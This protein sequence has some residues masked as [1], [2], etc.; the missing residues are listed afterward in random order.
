[1]LE[2]KGV[3]SRFLR[4]N[5]TVVNGDGLEAALPVPPAALFIPEVQRHGLPALQLPKT[6]AA[7]AF[8]TIDVT[9]GFPGAMGEQ[10]VD[11]GM[12]GQ[13]ADAGFMSCAV[14]IVCSSPHAEK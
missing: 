11:R 5:E 7:E 2:I 12:L 9:D 3:F 10:Y 8:S 14:G 4:I 1:M 6:I 13:L